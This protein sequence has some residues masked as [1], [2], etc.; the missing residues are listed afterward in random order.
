PFSFRP[1]LQVTLY[2][3]VSKVI[4]K[5]TSNGSA[6]ASGVQYIDQN[7]ITHTVTATNVIRSAGT[8]GS[9]TILEHS[10]VGNK[11]F[12]ASLGIRSVID[13]PGVGENLQE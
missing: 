9:P 12:L 10:G 3:T 2:S 4:W 1:N 6:V 5:S 11:T 13:L 7:G 8:L